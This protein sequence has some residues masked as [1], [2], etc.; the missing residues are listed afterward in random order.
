MS[1]EQARGRSLDKRTDLWSF[2]CLLYEVLVGRPTVPD[3]IAQILE[4]DPD[5]DALPTKLHP[6]GSESCYGDVCRRMRSNDAGI[7]AM[8]GLKSSMY[9]RTLQ[10]R[11]TFPRAR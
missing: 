4:R 6:R 2:G 9:W 3:N 8:R 10:V 5:W 11:C 1:P 7:L